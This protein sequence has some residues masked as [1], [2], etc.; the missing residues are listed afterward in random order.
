MKLLLAIICVIFC[1]ATSN[2]IRAKRD[3]SPDVRNKLIEVLNK[4]RQEIGKKLNI[5]M[6]I[7]KYDVSL[8]RSIVWSEDDCNKTPSWFGGQHLNGNSIAREVMEEHKKNNSFRFFIPSYKTIGC[9]KDFKCS[10][11]VYSEVRD[12]VIG[13]TMVLRGLCIFREAYKISKE[14][15]DKLN[16]A[17]RPMPWK[18]G[19]IIGVDGPSPP[20][21]SDKDQGSGS[22]EAPSGKGSEAGTA[23][24]N[25]I[26]AKR[27]LSPDVRNKLIKVLNKDRQEIG[28]KLNISMEILK[29]DLAIERSIVWSEDDCMKSPSLIGGTTLSGDSLAL[30]IAKKYSKDLNF[31]I[32]SH[33]TI[34]CSKDFKCSNTY[35]TT[36]IDELKGKTAVFRGICLF[37]GG[38]SQDV[39]KENFDKIS[40]AEL[41]MPW[42]Y[43]DIIGVNGPSGE[44]SA[45]VQGSGSGEAPS[46]KG[47]G[48]G[49]LKFDKNN[50]R[51]LVNKMAM[52]LFLTII[53]VI[54][55][56]AT[57][58]EIRAKRDLSPDV[59]NKLIE[60][61]NKDR[62]EIGKKLNI[63]MEIMKYDVS[64]EQSIIW[65]ENDCKKTP[66]FWKGSTLGG[67]SLAREIAEKRKASE[68][69]FQPS[70]KTVGCSKD[71]KCSITYDDTSYVFEKVRWKTSILLGFCNFEGGMQQFV[72]NTNKV[73][74]P[75]P[76]KYGDIIG[77]EGSTPP[78]ESATDQV[79]GSGKAQS[80]KGS[81]CGSVLILKFD[82]NNHREL[83]NK[84][85]MKLLLTIICVI[86]CSATSNEIRAKRD[87]SPDVRNKLI[88]VLNKDRQELG[89]K[90][91]ISME[92][93]KYDVSLERSIVWSEDDCNKTPSFTG[94]ST[95][96]GDSLAREVI[97]KYTQG[98][99]FFI[100]SYKTIGCS[101]DFKCKDT[102][103]SNVIDKSMIG[104]TA[105]YR[106]FCI[107]GEKW[108]I[109]DEDNIKLHEAERPLPFKYAAIIGVDGPSGEGS[110]KDQGSGF[111]EAPSGKGSGAGI[112]K[113]DKNNHRK[114][115]NRMA[116]KLFLAIICVIFSAANSNEI[117]A[118][119][120]LSPDVRNKLIEVLNKDRQEIGK[121]LNIKME[122][123]KYDLAIERS[124]VLSEDDC[125][126]SPSWKKGIIL[127]DESLLQVEHNKGF[128][129]FI[130]S[131]K[132]IGCSKDFKCSVENTA[133][134]L[135]HR[136]ICIFGEEPNDD[137]HKL[138]DE[139]RYNLIVAELPTPS[140]YGDIIGVN[141]PSSTEESVT[142]QGSGS[143]EAPSGTSGSS[144]KGTGAES[145]FSLIMSL[146]LVLFI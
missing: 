95:I 15:N 25:E 128:P 23:T 138:P 83:V 143:G 112:L 33:K 42:K 97:E 59:R 119:R 26:R 91:N 36:S 54:F 90:L 63:S 117:R 131:R 87:L 135:V 32:P 93:M 107:F 24:S 121:K 34:G 5:K 129:F 57:S 123:V 98:Y 30:E 108:K 46:G 45:N 76:W 21:G 127:S 2:E 74:Y 88:E 43:G 125:L 141:G 41:P 44:G 38:S 17:E 65:S 1:S 113:V 89:K 64:L 100:P 12:E 86:F 104:K 139:D 79:S 11:T 7:M 132:T 111:G 102:F 120:D 144:G 14:D 85:A 31:F 69:F 80:G 99:G 94:L 22:G 142:V 134:T 56:A 4:D 62:Q 67:D 48:A 73:D 81:G 58:N 10:V 118:K 6:E 114:L 51:K 61:L 29:Y 35:N 103:D 146:F 145:V 137:Y 122:I 140:K 19:D 49:I 16:E 106:G 13:K 115:V 60:V 136:G 9:S 84:M 3:L 52:K 92:T 82:K 66:F 47:S 27:E 18:Y 68:G 130:P 71:F 96:S 101:K 77:V 28:K 109:S 110:A 8:E 70:Y 55:S 105:V 78:E 53:C 39:S 37:G 50:H 124:I 126:K 116:M 72:P 75:M 40:N 133:E 20:G